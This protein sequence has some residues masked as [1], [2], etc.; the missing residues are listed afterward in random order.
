MLFITQ[1]ATYINMVSIYFVWFSL[2]KFVHYSSVFPFSFVMCW[3]WH[4]NDSGRA[5]RREVDPIKFKQSKISLV[6]LC[7]QLIHKY[8]LS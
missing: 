3:V 2:N 4:S 6:V 7:K 8:Q 1:A 5:G